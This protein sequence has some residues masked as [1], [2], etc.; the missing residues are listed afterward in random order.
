MR[1]GSTGIMILDEHEGGEVMMVVMMVVIM[2]VMMVVMMVAV[3]KINDGIIF[4]F[5]QVL[6]AELCALSEEN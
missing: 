4:S 6:P 2:V 1:K 3:V 5:F